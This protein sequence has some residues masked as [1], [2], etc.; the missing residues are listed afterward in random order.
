MTTPSALVS[1]LWN[2]RFQPDGKVGSNDMNSPYF[3]LVPF[4]AALL[5][6]RAGGAGPGR[7]ERLVTGLD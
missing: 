1:K 7:V 3:C 6:L 5:A 2:Y 4:T